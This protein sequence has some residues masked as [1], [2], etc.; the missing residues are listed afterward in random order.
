[1]M[2]VKQIFMLSGLGIICTV[3]F[4][5]VRKDMPEQNKLTV[6]VLEKIDNI[7]SKSKTFSLAT[8]NP[9]TKKALTKSHSNVI[10][11]DE[12]DLLSVARKISS[13]NRTVLVT[14]VNDAYLKFTYS[15]LC[16]TKNMGIHKSVLIITTDQVSK[17]NLTRD[18]PEVSVVAMDMKLKG[19]QTYS[20]VGYVKI[21]VKRTEMILSI[22]M[23]DIEV[24]VFE[25][26]C[27]WLANPIPD[28]QSITGYDILVNPV[29]RTNNRVFAGGFLWLYVT[30]KAKAV[31]KKVT[32]QM[33]A[34]GERIS[35]MSD[36][37][38]VSEGE[39]DQQFFSRLINER[40]MNVSIKMLNLDVYA[41]GQWYNL[42]EDKRNQSHPVIINN[43][44]VVGNEAKINRAKK[45]KHWF[46]HDDLTCDMDLVSQTV[47]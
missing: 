37:A 2:R 6:D 5:T 42:P 43:N 8:Q 34:L 19:D 26:D 41:D 36:N 40:Y 32:E 20:K 10:I 21:M 28:L 16:N 3:L 14:M 46:I 4:I 23:A 33:I 45:W 17:D 38:Q 13:Y 31:W 30:D 39:N 11:E 35:K 18:W 9:N 7:V 44:W 1:M 29:A 12:N 24:F 27:L 25:V 15:W 47:Y 22:L